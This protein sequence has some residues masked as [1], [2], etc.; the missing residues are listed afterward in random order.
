V[1][2]APLKTWG[3]WTDDQGQVVRDSQRGQT[4]TF[5]AVAKPLRWLNVHYNQ[6]DSFFPQVVRQQLDLKSNVPNPRGEGKDYGFSFSALQ[7]K[8]NMKINRYQVTEYD[9]R[10]SEVGTIGNRTIRLE[11]RQEANG[12]RDANGFYPWAEELVLARFSTQGITTPSQAQLRPAIAKVMGQ[13]VEWLNT[14]LDSG[15]AQP[16]TVGTTDVTSKGIE[17][18]ATYNPTRNWRIKFTGAQGV[19]YDA[20]I[21]PEIY[22]YWQSRLPVWTTV[23]G[24]SVPGNGDGKGALWWTSVPARGGNTPE[25]QYNSALISPYSVGVANVGKPRTQV[26]EYRW[27]ALT[28]YE[29]SQGRLKGFSVGGGVRWVDKG[30]IGFLGVAPETSGP[31]TGAILSLDKNKPVWDAARFYFD[32]S[33]GYR[34]KFSNDRIR[35]R[36]QLNIKDVFES[37]R[38]QPVGVN[39]DGSY[40]AYRIIDPRRFILSTSF[41]L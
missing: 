35:G 3:Q 15:L 6:S 12:V 26:R 22:N 39:P 16:Q 30:S 32:F 25:A 19:A 37:G 21:S 31:F 7:G 5:G 8:L 24:D 38:L 13:S 10:G 18:E 9:S 1:T 11:G 14:F 20:A 23:R 28:N 34:F 36:V 2:Y 17:V 41:D 40:Y 4:R 27:N 29:F 33:A